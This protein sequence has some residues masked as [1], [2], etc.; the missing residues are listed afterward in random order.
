MQIDPLPPFRCMP[1]CFVLL[2]EDKAEFG[3]EAG[4]E[5]L[6]ESLQLEDYGQRLAAVPPILWL[7]ETRQ[8][9]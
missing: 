2:E 4:A 3:I 8:E 1:Q 7:L 6:H 9:V 5:C